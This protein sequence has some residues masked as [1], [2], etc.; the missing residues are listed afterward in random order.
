[1][2]D[3]TFIA[4]VKEI[5]TDAKTL[6]IEK[7]GGTW[8]YKYRNEI[9]Q[10]ALKTAVHRQEKGWEDLLMVELQR[11]GNLLKVRRTFV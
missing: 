1:M 8:K 7:K 11:N 2:N 5:D 3:D 9:P 6:T 4:R 10:E